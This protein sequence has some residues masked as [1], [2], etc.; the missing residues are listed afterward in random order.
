MRVALLVGLIAALTSACGGSLTNLPEGPGGPAADAASALQQATA[1]CRA[2]SSIT[3]EIGVSGSVGGR[4]MR[5]RLLAGLAAPASVRLEAPAPF[6][7]P[8]FIFTAR[9]TDA[10]VLLPRARRVLEHGRADAVLEAVAGVSMT[11]AELLTTVTGCGE[12]IPATGATSIGNEWIVIPGRRRVYLRRPRATDP[13]RLV[14]A[15]Q[16]DATGIEWRAEYSNFVGGL[17]RSI[18]LVSA[19]G[20]RFALRLE[21]SQVDTNVPIDVDAFRVEN[22]PGSEPISLEELRDSG[23]LGGSASGPDGP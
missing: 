10:T 23:P 3:A 13:W 16:H 8:V 15:V 6:G 14:A 11:P 17:P 19:D 22:P 1:T 21:L 18:R 12:E 9:G 2:V 20:R 5:A 7:Q 4:R